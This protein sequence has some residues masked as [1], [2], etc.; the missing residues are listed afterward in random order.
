MC[1]IGVRVLRLRSA[2]PVRSEAEGLRMTALGTRELFTP[3]LRVLP[4]P[5]AVN[6]TLEASTPQISAG[7]T[8]YSVSTGK[9]EGFWWRKYA[10]LK[11]DGI[12]WNGRG[13]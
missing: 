9:L 7:R 13:D 12:G 10:F 5:Q 6:P 8:D 3:A 4:P 1:R 11:L 2:E